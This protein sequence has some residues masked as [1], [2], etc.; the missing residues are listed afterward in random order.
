MI[1]AEYRP[2]RDLAPWVA[3]FWRIT[4][5][6]T[7]AIPFQHRVLPDGCADLLFDLSA[8]GAIE[9]VGPM[10]TAQVVDLSGSVDMLGVRLRPGAVTT[11]GGVHA[12]ELLDVVV[13]F[14]LH[15]SAAQVMEAGLPSGGRCSEDPFQ[16]QL[17]LVVDALRAHVGA[18][19]EPDRVI[20]HA[21]GRWIRAEAPDFPSVSILTRDVGLSERAFERR[22]IANV[23]LT[24]VS[25]RRLARL[26]TVFRLHAAGA[27]G[28]A[29]ISATTGFSDQAHLV[30]DCR[31]FTGLTPT[32]WAATQ[33]AR[34]GFL[35]DGAVTTD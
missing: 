29:A 16:A 25:Y 27:R 2:P 7:E 17:R 14:S 23:G 19:D 30:R 3:C 1:Y 4:G 13:P 12:G 32:E 28:W 26:R 5:C 9:L 21:L 22:F 33:A 8:G 24:P 31:A 15:V 20:R 11:F 34:A 10:S 35:Q 18:L 6:A